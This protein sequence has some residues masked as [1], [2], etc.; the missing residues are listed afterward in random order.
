MSNELNEL[1]QSTDNATAENVAEESVTTEIQNEQP[2]QSGEEGEKP[3]NELTP[4]AQERLG[5][6]IKA[7]RERLRA[8]YARTLDAERQRIAA[9]LQHSGTQPTQ[10]NQSQVFDPETGEYVD[11]SSA[12]GQIL[13]RKQKILQRQAEMRAQSEYAQLSTKAQEGYDR[14]IETYAD[15][16]EKFVQ[17]GTDWM[18]EALKGAEDP[19]A[20]INHLGT[21]PEEIKRIAQLPPARQAREIILIDT[22]L[23]PP[24]KLVSNAKQPVSH[25]NE[26]RNPA[27]GI[28]NQSYEQREAYYRKRFNME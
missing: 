8:Q 4:E 15:A 25:V 27:V 12:I 28:E 24:K 21:H 14:F 3:K 18:A 11:T 6:A 1:N 23:N 22:R 26:S 9:E 2:E 10:T 17:L 13:S 20:V 5:K 16:H 19:S 7:E